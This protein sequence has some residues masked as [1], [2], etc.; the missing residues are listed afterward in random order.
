MSFMPTTYNRMVARVEE[1]AHIGSFAGI[2][3]ETPRAFLGRLSSLA[4]PLL[5][6]TVASV[7]AGGMLQTKQHDSLATFLFLRLSIVLIA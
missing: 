5:V 3:L 4:H 6:L 7:Y 1:P 2:L